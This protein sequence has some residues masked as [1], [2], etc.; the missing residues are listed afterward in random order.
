M[1]CVHLMFFWTFQN[2]LLS[3]PPLGSVKWHFGASKILNMNSA[4]L[5]VRSYTFHH[6]WA[7]TR[8]LGTISMGGTW[9]NL[10]PLAIGLLPVRSHWQDWR[11][12]ETSV[13]PGLQRGIGQRRSS[14]MFRRLSS[15]P[16]AQPGHPMSSHFHPIR[17]TTWFQCLSQKAETHVC[18][19]HTKM[20]ANYE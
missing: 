17:S 1:K 8:P 3:I 18:C 6:I 7:A 20:F 16:G 19:I 2:M 12:R 10:W 11:R 9:I 5:P 14:P 15:L 13:V 4:V